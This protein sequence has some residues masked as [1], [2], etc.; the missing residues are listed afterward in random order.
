MDKNANAKNVKRQMARVFL[1]GNHL[2]SVFS[3]L[4]KDISNK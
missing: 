3:S 2:W 1:E 4:F